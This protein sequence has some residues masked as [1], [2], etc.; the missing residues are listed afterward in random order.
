[1]EASCECRVYNK[2]NQ[3]WDAEVT[4]RGQGNGHFGFSSFFF[5][6]VLTEGT[7]TAKVLSSQN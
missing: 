2:G 1:M 6:R 7:V 5:S 3:L 4:I